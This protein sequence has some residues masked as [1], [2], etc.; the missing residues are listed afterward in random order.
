VLAGIIR[1]S[2]F[3]QEST[4]TSSH[5]LGALSGVQAA[6]AI[7]AIPQLAARLSPPEA[8]ALAWEGLTSLQRE[9]LDRNYGLGGQPA[10]PPYGVM[11]QKE[12]MEYAI[13]LMEIWIRTGYY[14]LTNPE[15]YLLLRLG[16]QRPEQLPALINR[17]TD[18]RRFGPAR[19]RNINAWMIAHGY[20]S[21]IPC[22]DDAAR[23]RFKISV[24]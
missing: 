8:V 18:Y 9:I 6:G 4:M 19:F 13:M 22:L 21:L 7:A 11:T 16:A 15:L 2:H 24:Q 20:P 3:L 10:S 12:R 23:A 5:V 14:G 17:T 1:M